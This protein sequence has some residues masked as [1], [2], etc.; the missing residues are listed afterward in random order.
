MSNMER[1]TSWQQIQ[2][3]VK[4][5]E[6]LIAR[7]EYNL[8][9]VKA[10]QVLE[11]MVRCMAER[12]CLVEGDLSETIDELYDGC[13]I[14]RETKDNYHTIRILG[15]KAVHEGSNA[16]HDANQAY[17]LMTQEVYVFAEEFSGGQSGRGQHRT[18]RTGSAGS[19]SG[20]MGS[21][22]HTGSSGVRPGVRARNGSG[23]SRRP[24]YSGNARQG[25][26][27]KKNRRQTLPAFYM[28]RL[29]IPLLVIVLLIVVIRT[30]TPSGKDKDQ[31]TTAAVSTSP[32]VTTAA[33]EPAPTQPPVPETAPETEAP[34]LKYK[35][36]GNSVNVR[37]DPSKD[38][39]I[40]VQ[41]AKGTEVDY[42]KRYN[43][44][45]DVI[46]YDGQEAYVSSQFL[47]KVEPASSANPDAG[48]N[49][50]D[51]TAASTAAAAAH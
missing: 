51:T 46:N 22:G 7:K 25:G 2:L 8:V 16:A 38:S 11:Y 49:T 5:A 48:S 3:G 33:P 45:W 24:A 17:R 18:A 10:R 40:L 1:T 36:K 50:A 41:L 31:V 30:L 32:Q 29:L 27:R 6:R 12:A 19:G 37:K 43:N 35:V 47:E 26:P 9:M 13:W 14:S 21:A 42:V 34:A 4:D 28:W 15:N 39:R 20:R 23:P 44:D